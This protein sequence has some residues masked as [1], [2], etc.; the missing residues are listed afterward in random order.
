MYLR[1]IYF[2]LFFRHIINHLWR[3]VL[4]F[5]SSLLYVRS[6][7]HSDVS[8]WVISYPFHD[9]GRY[10]I[11][12]SSL[13]CGVNQWTAFY[14]ITASVIKGLNDAVNLA[15]LILAKIN[16]CE[17]SCGLIFCKFRILLKNQCKLSPSNFTCTLI[18]ANESQWNFL[19]EVALFNLI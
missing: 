7:Y 12:T 9:G 17:L 13:I 19:L 3:I 8:E 4:K 5:F 2:L 18:G 15:E 11:E 1:S 16:V 6:Q 14:M 10:H